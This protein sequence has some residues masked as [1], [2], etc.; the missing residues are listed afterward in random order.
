MAGSRR[1]RRGRSRTRTPRRARGSAATRACACSARGR[2]SRAARRAA[3]PARCARRRRASSGGSTAGRARRG[4]SRPGA[5]QDQEARA[6]VGQVADP[7]AR[8]SR[9]NRAAARGERTAAAPALARVGD[10]LAGTGR[11]VG[12]QELP[13]ARRAG[14]PRPGRAPGCAS[15]RAR[16]H[17]RRWPGSAAR[18]SRRGRRPRRDLEVVLDAAG[19]SS[20]GRCR[21]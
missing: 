14:T 11:V 13:R 21:G 15:R 10:G 17:R 16:C 7:S 1:R 8:T 3:C 2:R 18:H 5:G 4:R 9:P 19:R 20:R 12:R 6:V